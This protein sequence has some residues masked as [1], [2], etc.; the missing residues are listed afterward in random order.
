MTV[1]PTLS[2]RLLLNVAA[3]VV[4]V[5]ALGNR[6]CEPGGFIT[7]MR[8]RQSIACA[9]VVALFKRSV[10]QGDDVLGGDALG[11]SGLCDAPDGG[12]DVFR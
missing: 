8:R 2:D 4:V 5:F 11:G 9:M 7:V 12:T 6:C 1:I 3:S 10:C